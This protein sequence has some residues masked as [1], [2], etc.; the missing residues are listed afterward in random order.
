MLVRATIFGT[1]GGMGHINVLHFQQTDATTI[2]YLALGQI[3][4]DFWIGAHVGNTQSHMQWNKIKIQPLN[5]GESPY[6]WSV[7]RQ[8]V[9]GFTSAYIPFLCAVFKFRTGGSGRKSR[10][11]S[12]QG[13]YDNSFQ[14]AAGLWNSTL[15]TRLDN[16]AAA[17]T[18]DWCNGGSS[19]TMGWGLVV[20]GRSATLDSDAFTVLEITASSKVG[21]MN[22]RKIGRG[23]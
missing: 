8:G 18:S 16:V 23:L 9:L 14:I 20:A 5:G 21:T 1:Y 13:G 6:E 4:E 3:V 12:S 10:G 22:T 15:Q 19:N 2:L 17:L 7:T 11:R